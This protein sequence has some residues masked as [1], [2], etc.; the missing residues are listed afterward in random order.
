MKL[1]S[2]QER[3]GRVLA[4][5]YKQRLITTSEVKMNVIKKSP[6]P[7]TTT[8]PTQSQLVALKDIISCHAYQYSV[9]TVMTHI[10]EDD[11]ERYIAFASMTSA[12]KNYSQIMKEALCEVFSV[13]NSISIYLERLL[14]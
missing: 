13:K 7:T 3:G 1:I 8:R 10:M 2:V 6:D 11:T 9:G 4:F 14:L 12:E 5:Y